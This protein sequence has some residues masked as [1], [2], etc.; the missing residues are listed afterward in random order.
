MQFLNFIINE[1]KINSAMK[2]KGINTIEELSKQLNV[3]RNTILPYLSGQRALPDCLDRMLKLLDLTPADAIV[4]NVKSKIQ[5]GLE[6]SPLLSKL[7][8]S[9]T[10]NSYVLFGSRAKR[11]NKKYS[12]YDIGVYRINKLPFSD[13]SKLIDLTDDWESDKSYDVNLTNLTLADTDFLQNIRRDWIFL[14]GNLEAWV[15]LQKKAGIEL[16]E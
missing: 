12:D 15:E 13:L 3:H 5:P 4:K 9:Q 16:Y 10:E 1:E 7:I 6:I 14:G 11:T 8:T 2:A